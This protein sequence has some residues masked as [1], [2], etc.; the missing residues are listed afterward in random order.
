[1]P[2]YSNAYGYKRRSYRSSKRY[3]KKANVSGE[4]RPDMVIQSIGNQMGYEKARMDRQV[5]LKQNNYV[6][7]S[8][9]YAEAQGRLRQ[10]M[11]RAGDFLRLGR[12]LDGFEDLGV[13]GVSYAQP[14]GSGLEVEPYLTLLET[15]YH[16]QSMPA[17][18]RIRIHA[19]F[20][21]EVF[22]GAYQVYMDKLQKITPIQTATHRGQDMPELTIQDDP[23]RMG[24]TDFHQAYPSNDPRD[25]LP[26]PWISTAES[27]LP[28][29]HA[30]DANGEPA[31]KR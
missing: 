21:Y 28:Q 25:T 16:I 22:M 30:P 6:F 1:M 9:V 20:L 14:G 17:A 26:N 12:A 11:A 4:E 15:K 19:S 13:L 27:L 7:S 31:A 3:Y 5:F 29:A 23:R 24:A 18:N 8:Y 10:L 2:Y